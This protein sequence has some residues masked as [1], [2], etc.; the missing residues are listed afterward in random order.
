MAS[1][2]RSRRGFTLI[3]LLTVIGI[4]AVLAAILFP[5]FANVRGKARQTRCLSNL[6]QIGQALLLYV[7]DNN[8]RIVPWSITHGGTDPWTPPDA[9]E[10]H[11]A[12]ETV[13]TWD[14]SIMSYLREEEL[15]ICVDNPNS[16]WRTAR[17]YSVAQYTQIPLVLG[18]RQVALGGFKDDIPA[19]AR[20]VMLF[21]KGNWPA[22]PDDPAEPPPP[23]YGAW[24]DALGQNVYQYHGE[25]RPYDGREGGIEEPG[26]FPM[27]HSGGKN[28]LFVDGHAKWYR[29][30]AGPFAHKPREDATIGDCE[31]WGPPA[32]G[33]DWPVPGDDGNDDNDD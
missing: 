8:G 16:N 26:D 30:G 18:G 9:N 24:G 17:S 3:E 21:E 25:D 29:S 6:Q 15:L 2:F 20:T 22:P 23:P 5:V 10:R 12:N 7:Q 4:I 11:E 1:L 28:F 32:R 13:A 14:V 27:W 19:P 33:G 31:H